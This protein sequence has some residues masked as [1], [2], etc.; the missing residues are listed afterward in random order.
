MIDPKTLEA[1]AR[2]VQAALLLLGHR[3]TDEQAE[4]VANAALQAG[5]GE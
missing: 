3:L 1:A 5:G 2:A 4:Y